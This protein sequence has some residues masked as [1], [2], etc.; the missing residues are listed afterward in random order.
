MHA[1]VATLQQN[2]DIALFLSVPVG[3]WFGSLKFGS[4]SRHR[5]H[6]QRVIRRVARR[7]FFF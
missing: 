3:F 5:N 4:F 7:I 1:L 2:P 6:R